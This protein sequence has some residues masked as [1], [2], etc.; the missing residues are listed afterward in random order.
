MQEE[1]ERARVRLHRAGDVAED[2][3]LAG[4]TFW[5][6]SAALDELAARA[7]ATAGRAGAGRAF[8]PLG[9]GRSR[10]ER[11]LRPRASR[12]RARSRV[13]R[14]ARPASASRSRAAAGAPSTLQ[15]RRARRRRARPVALRPRRRPSRRTSGADRATGSTP[16]SE[17]GRNH[18]GEGDGRSARARPGARDERLTQRPV[19]VAP[20]VQTD[21]VER[22]SAPRSIRPGPTSSPSSR[23]DR[24]NVTSAAHERR[25]VG[26]RRAVTRASAT[27]SPSRPSRTASR[28]SWYLSTDPSVVSTTPCVEL[29][30]SER[31][32]RLRPVDR[33]RDTRRL[34]EVEPAQAAA[35]TPR[36]RARASRATPGTAARRS[37]PLAP[38]TDGRSSGRG[39]GA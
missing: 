23:S 22:A 20:V 16:A 38:E 8:R 12:R 13:P 35:R 25:A 30:D 2:D 24:P 37:R 18:A 15:P 27:S 31:R 32:Q 5:R 9:L 19:D 21:C 10:R 39:S 33:L 11:R 1:E 17:R 28:S 34:L 29:H 26:H 36:P 3:E 6:G 7:R 14:R 4:T